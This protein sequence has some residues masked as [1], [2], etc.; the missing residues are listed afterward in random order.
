MSCESASKWLAGVRRG[1]SR[2]LPL[3][4]AS[5]AGLAVMGWRSAARDSYCPTPLPASGPSALVWARPWDDGGEMGGSERPWST[6]D[7]AGGAQ[8]RFASPASGPPQ[9]RGL[10][11]KEQRLAPAGWRPQ[12]EG[13]DGGGDSASGKSGFELE[14]QIQFEMH[15]SR[16]L[17][18]E[19]RLAAPNRKGVAGRG[20]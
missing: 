12:A 13:G 4:P 19:R 14:S 7:S 2:P 15:P 8:S 11:G 18:L 1:S 16:L 3:R 6:A 5:R 20:G 9:G 17:K 10:S